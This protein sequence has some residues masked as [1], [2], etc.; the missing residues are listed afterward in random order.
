MAEVKS[1][2]FKSASVRA[3]RDA[4]LQRSLEHV[5]EHFVDARA[6]AIESDYGADNWE[7]MRSRAAAIKQSTIESLDYYLDLV[8][9]NVRR[10]G[11]HVHFADDAAQANAIVLDIAR[12]NGVKSV[13]KSKSMVSEETGVNHALERDGIEVVETDLGEYIIQLAGETPFHIIAPAMHKT[14]D[15]VS[16]LFQQWLKTAPTQDIKRLCEHARSALR[17]KFASADMGISGANFVV[18]ETGSVCLVTN[19]GNG[20][21]TTSAP[22]VHVALAG[23][24][25][26]IPAWEDLA[27]FLR[28]L[29]RS[30]TGQRITSY[31]TF[32]GG[33]RAPSDEDGPEEFHLVIV[34]NGRLNLLRDEA[35][36]EALRCI[37]CGACLNHCP[38]YRK[39]GGHAYGWVYSGPIGAVVTPPMTNMKAAKD[40][41]Y[42]STLCGMCRDVCPVKIDIPRLLLHLRHKVAEGEDGERGA[43]WM[44]R[45]FVERWSK[46]MRDRKSLEGQA[47]LGRL[48]TKPLTRGGRIRKLPAPMVGG[49]TG[50]RDF[51]APA[52]RSF[53]QLWREELA[54][55]GAQPPPPQAPGA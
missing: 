17:E 28:L 40:L 1:A 35:M 51:P 34:D 8:D 15:D 26:I 52:P 11:G 2:E 20:R 23:M 22:L 30:A 16:A 29:P 10:N 4:K 50:S 39:V 48:L 31:N 12:R 13:I 21:M 5:M 54:A 37:R 46:A 42:A 27:L 43:T 53:A 49:W 18:A 9:K 41:P 45:L 47:R 14:R 3:L 32:V 38:V 36:R 24:E 19:E 55:D 7:A 25:K 33:P 44:E 6:D